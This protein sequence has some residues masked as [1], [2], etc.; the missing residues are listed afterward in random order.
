[1]S[2]T[3]EFFQANLE[4]LPPKNRLNDDLAKVHAEKYKTEVHEQ[5]R[6]IEA[7]SDSDSESNSD[8]NFDNNNDEA[9]VFEEGKKE[10]VMF[11]DVQGADGSGSDSETRPSLVNGLANH[12]RDRNIEIVDEDQDEVL[13]IDVKSKNLFLLQRTDSS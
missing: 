9:F 3:F 5:N 13:F 2:P 4:R 1:M 6:P 7:L 10:G 11:I 12:R 8:E